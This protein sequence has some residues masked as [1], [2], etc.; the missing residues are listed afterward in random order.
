[1]VKKWRLEHLRRVFGSM[2]MAVA[3]IPY[4]KN[5]AKHAS[6]R[7]TRFDQYVLDLEQCNDDGPADLPEYWFGKVNLDTK[8]GQ[9]FVQDV[10]TP[11]VLLENER[12]R[13]QSDYYQFFCGSSGAGSPQHLHGNAWNALV[14]GAQKEWYFWSPSGQHVQRAPASRPLHNYHP[15]LIVTQR[16]GDIVLFPR[17]GGT[18]HCG[19]QVG[20]QMI[21]EDKNVWLEEVPVSASLS[22]FPHHIQT[23]VTL[24]TIEII[25]RYLHQNQLQILYSIITENRVLTPYCLGGFV[26][27]ML[28]VISHD[29]FNPS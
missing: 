24:L 16:E 26:F 18:Q 7:E 2:S 8:I 13:Y 5:Y 27:T 11:N 10:V 22:N 23:I 4:K 29:E 6:S 12:F 25:P 20:M 21:V 19:A 14:R 15:N 9:H 1:M 28:Q 17:T 3:D